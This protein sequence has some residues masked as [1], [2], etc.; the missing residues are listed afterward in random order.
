[1]Q[2]ELFPFEVLTDAERRESYQIIRNSYWFLRNLRTGRFGQARARKYYRL[3]EAQK[4]RLLMAGE[5][6]REVLDLLACCRLQCSRHKH[7]FKPCK[8]CLSASSNFA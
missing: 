4:K 3:V 1:M 8:Y 5:S 2:L 6:K 7:P